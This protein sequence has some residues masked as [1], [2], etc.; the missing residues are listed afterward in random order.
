MQDASTNVD[1]PPIVIYMYIPLRKIRRH[2]NS[3]K[4][5]YLYVK[6][7]V[8]ND[9]LRVNL[10][11]SA[12]QSS[13]AGVAKKYGRTLHSVKTWCSLKIYRVLIRQRGR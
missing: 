10:S 2:E 5:I 7:R 9:L 13:N 12:Q 4:P 1:C 8:W 3:E 11:S 6:F